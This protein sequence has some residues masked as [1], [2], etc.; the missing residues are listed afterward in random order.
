MLNNNPI[1]VAIFSVWSC[2]TFQRNH[3]WWSIGQNR[4]YAIHIEFRKRGIPHVHSFIW[5][6]NAPNIENETVYI[7]CIKKTNFQLLDHLS[8]AQ[9]SELAITKF[10]LTLKFAEN[11]TRANVASP[12]VNNFLRQLFQNYLTANLPVIKGKRC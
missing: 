5:I 8:N 9:L 1:L 2:S 6:L 11:T 12:I 7:E 4:N 3:T 10:M